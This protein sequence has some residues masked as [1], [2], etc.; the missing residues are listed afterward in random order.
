MTDTPKLIKELR[1]AH[2]G[3]A[4]E[5][6]STFSEAADLLEE[7]QRDRDR[8]DWILDNA[9]IRG[10]GDGFTIKVFVPVDCECA[11]TGIDLVIEGE[12]E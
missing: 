12:T 1:Q 8:L 3:H 5:G 6:A 2:T 11:R 4:D 9:S 10:G 7:L